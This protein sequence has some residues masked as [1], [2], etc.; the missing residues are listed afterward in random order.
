MDAVS[1]S[2]LSALRSALLNTSGTVPLHDRFRALFTLKS[3]KNDEAVKI[4]SEG[5]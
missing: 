5:M 3:L 4:I 2:E 1:P